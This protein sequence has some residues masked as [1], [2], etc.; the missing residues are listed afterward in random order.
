MQR[1]DLVGLAIHSFCDAS[2]E[3]VPIVDQKL[4]VNLEEWRGL[5]LTGNGLSRLSPTDI[6]LVDNRR[7]KFE[8]ILTFVCLSRILASQTQSGLNDP[9]TP[10]QSASL[11]LDRLGSGVRCGALSAMPL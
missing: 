1:A 11:A 8:K 4:T 9:L 6:L 2:Q 10:L 7:E 5:V 3:F